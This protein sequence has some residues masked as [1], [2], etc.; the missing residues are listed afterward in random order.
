V[1]ILQEVRD[2]IFVIIL[3]GGYSKYAGQLW[4]WSIMEVLANFSDGVKVQSSVR[5]LGIHVM[6]LC[7]WLQ[8]DIGRLTER[9]RETEMERMRDVARSRENRRTIKVDIL[10]G[11]QLITAGCGTPH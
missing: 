1:E 11:G 2:Q 10:C 6:V 3:S 8:A 7:A 9:K 4:L 5:D